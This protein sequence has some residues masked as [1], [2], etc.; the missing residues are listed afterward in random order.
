MFINLYSLSTITTIFLGSTNLDWQGAVTIV[1]SSFVHWAIRSVRLKGIRDGTLSVSENTMYKINKLL[2]IRVSRQVVKKKKKDKKGIRAKSPNRI[3]HADITTL[4]TLDNKRYYI[5][6]VIDNYSR[7]ILS[8]AISDKVSGLVTTSTIQEAYTKASAITKSLNVDLIVDG[9]PENNN[10]HINN[11]ISQSEINIQKLVALRDINF[12]NSMI[13]RVNMTLKYRYIFPKNPRDLK[14][15][16]RILRYFIYD[17]N[18][19][20]PHGQLKG[21]TPNEAYIGL[22]IDDNHR[23]QVLQQARIARLAHN[24]GNTCSKC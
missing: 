1:W 11:F 21:L 13:E 18:I 2:D 20:R 6:L 5:S 12:S 8:Y 15:L 19:I 3:W 22:K 24:R 17:Y 23:T 10:I 14:H 16:Q 4:K 9:G 7:C